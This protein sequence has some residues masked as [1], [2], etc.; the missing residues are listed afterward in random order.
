MMNINSYEECNSTVIIISKKSFKIKSCKGKNMK[1]ISQWL[2]IDKLKI[3]FKSL[4][5]KKIYILTNCRNTSFI[6]YVHKQS[7]LKEKLSYL[8][9]SSTFLLIFSVAPMIYIAILVSIEFFN[10]VT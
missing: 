3:L 10:L 5:R 4:Q 8:Q 9:N 1:T 6:C 7:E 2:F